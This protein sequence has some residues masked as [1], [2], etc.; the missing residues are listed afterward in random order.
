MALLLA[1]MER[2]LRADELLG[3]R[4]L[5]HELPFDSDRK[6][7]TVV[8]DEPDGTPR[9]H[10]GRARSRRRSLERRTTALDE[11]ASAWA[12]EGFRVL[13]VSA[14][15]HRRRRPRRRRGRAHVLLGVVALHDPLR[16]TAAR[17][18]AAARA[19]GI[20]VRMLTGDHPATAR[21]IGHALGLDDGGDRRPRDAGRQAHD[22]S[23]SCSSRGEVVAVTGDGVNDAPALR[24]ADVGVAMGRSGTEAAREAAAI[25]LT[26]DDFA[27]IIAAVEEGR[28]IGDNIRKF[29]AFLLSANLGEVLVFAVAIIA[30]LGAP[31]AVIQVLMVNLVTDGLPAVALA[32]DPASAGTMTSPPRRGTQLF[33][34]PTWL[35]LGGIGVLVGGA[36]LAAFVAGRAFGGGTAQTMA[37][38]TLALSELA[39][40]FGIR[41]PQAH[42]W[43]LPRNRWLLWSTIGSAALVAAVVYLPLAHEPFATVSLGLREALVVAVLSVAPLIAVETG[44]TL[45]RRTSRR[46]QEVEPTR[47]RQWHTH[48][49]A[50]R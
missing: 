29:V 42:A 40:V 45:V 27:T 26:D 2:G 39:L 6:R 12:G 3:E 32:Q 41:S 24:R 18:L 21:T 7:M 31:L 14:R 48:A 43:Q 20:D 34:I 35:A 38:A 4:D 8:Y 47:T 49:G 22:S 16:E 9:L 33:D 44:K 13:A 10:E 19:A 23:R 46:T 25:V 30:G 28:R 37:F 17:S 36:T 1:A 50:P 15:A 11:V 5:V